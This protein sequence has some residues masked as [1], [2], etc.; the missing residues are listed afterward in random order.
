MVKLPFF[1]NDKAQAGNILGLVGVLIGLAVLIALGGLVAS[2]ITG[3]SALPEGDAFNVS[4]Q[5]T[6]YFGLT[7][8]MAYIA[9]FAA[10]G[11][12]VL[13]MVLGYFV[14]RGQGR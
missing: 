5:T 13:G 2:Q 7:T 11:M 1:K 4:T 9:V 8:E 3:A 6:E 14:M 10:I 12:V